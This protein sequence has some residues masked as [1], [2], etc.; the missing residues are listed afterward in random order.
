MRFHSYSKGHRVNNGREDLIPPRGFGGRTPC[1]QLW[2][3]KRLQ[4][5]GDVF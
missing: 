4:K 1:L 2:K 3:E 5:K